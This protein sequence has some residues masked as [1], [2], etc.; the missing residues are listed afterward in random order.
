MKGKMFL[1]AFALFCFSLAISAAPIKK[2]NLKVL[3]VGGTS[4]WEE[5][6]LPNSN[7]ASHDSLVKDRMAAFES[8]LKDYF[9]SVTVMKA[10]DYVQDMSYKYD[11]TIMDG[12]PKPISPL[13][14]NMAERIYMKP[15]YLTEDF[16][17]PML[18]IA[19]LSD[20]MTRRIGGKNDW[21]CLCLDNYAF[22]WKKSNPIFNGPYKV[23][24]KVE[25]RKTP[26]GVYGFA[27]A[28][29]D[30]I[31]P[32]L[33]MWEVQTK[34][35]GN[36]TGFRIGM[37][38]RPWGY[39]DSPEAE[40]I[41]GGVSQKSLDAVAIGR[42]GNFLHWGFSASPRYMTEA[43][44]AVFANAVVYI[45]KFA[46]KGIIARKYSDRVSNRHDLAMYEFLP[47]KK[48]YDS[49]VEEMESANR[50]LQE[51]KDEAIA[52][53]AK[54]EALTQVDSVYINYPI[55][56]PIGREEMLKMYCPKFYEMFGADSTA[57][58]NYINEN[59][60][61]FCDS[62]GVGEL[63]VDED[64]KSLGIAVDDIRLIDTAISM[65][66]K[67][68]DTEK[69]KR[70]LVRFTL[71]DFPTA[72]QWRAWF[73]KNRS[74]MFF[75][76]SGGW[77]W[78][79]NSR[80]KGVN[81]YRRWEDRK[82]DRFLN[83]GETSDQDPVSIAGYVQTLQNGQKAVY[84]KVRVHPGYHIYNFV[85]KADPFIPTEVTIALPD[86]FKKVGSLSIPRS[87]AIDTAGTTAFE[88]ES[89]FI[90]TFE[91]SGEGSVECK[92]YYQ[93]CNNG[94]CFPPKEKT[95]TLKVD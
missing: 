94:I 3:Y 28:D 89:T 69:A 42:H 78:L 4:D 35:Y 8:F 31:P 32:T 43:G 2:S 23:D 68:T 82:A 93:C 51:M 74:N 56:D 16:D 48:G 49:F 67:R 21:F 95:V 76:E 39:E 52:K 57:I 33:P 87:R 60:L 71:E 25:S 54:G 29:A 47:T 84:I 81:D 7:P 86:G 15:A 19:N 59:R 9:M 41:S 20:D 10:D 27:Y 11:V 50:M 40:S 72:A 26:D 55:S 88:G 90:Q 22:G 65:L 30:T 46:G 63:V 77:I 24:L 34:G 45:S 12:Q 53:Q 36:T 61:Y 62:Y 79:I 37:V 17:R 38:S 5:S 92:V 73:D 44:K 91:G 80:E 66:E 64:A 83:P 85:A 6:S 18:T 14:E 58:L 75:T 70:I 1:T 13:Y